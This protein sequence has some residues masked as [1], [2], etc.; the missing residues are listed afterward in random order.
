VSWADVSAQ[1]TALAF[2]EALRGVEGNAQSLATHQYC[3]S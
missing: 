2:W 3:G 1:L